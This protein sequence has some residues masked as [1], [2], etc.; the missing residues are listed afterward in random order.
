ML[1]EVKT[2]RSGN[3]LNLRKYSF[4]QFD[5]NG[6][7]NLNHMDGKIFENQNHESSYAF[8]FV[9]CTGKYQDTK[10]IT[11]YFDVHYG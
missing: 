4:G 7:F 10:N 5:E 11:H 2:I 1:N 3:G 8:I 9:L 6:H